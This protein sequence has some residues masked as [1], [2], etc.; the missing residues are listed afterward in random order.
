MSCILGYSEKT[1][2]SNGDSGTNHDFVGKQARGV[3]EVPVNNSE[4]GGGNGEAFG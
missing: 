2:E 4:E 3:E 1:K